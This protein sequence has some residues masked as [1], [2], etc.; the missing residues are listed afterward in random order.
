MID[1]SLIG[2]V[3]LQPHSW[4]S[5]LPYKNLICINLVS[6]NLPLSARQ[7]LSGDLLSGR[8]RGRVNRAAARLFADIDA[9]R[10]SLARQ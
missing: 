1:S 4:K 2:D 6:G 8:I 7:Q 5:G 10:A 9:F 3:S